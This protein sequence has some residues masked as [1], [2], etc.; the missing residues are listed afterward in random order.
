MQHAP[1]LTQL[2]DCGLDCHPLGSGKSYLVPCVTDA[3]VTVARC[4]AIVQ[5][6]ALELYG[7]WQG[8]L[9]QPRNRT[10]QQSAACCIVNFP[11]VQKLSAVHKLLCSRV[12]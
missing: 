12:Q 11:A 3:P 7:S 8:S 4:T 5:Q 1:L 6:S 9:V 2:R 10:L